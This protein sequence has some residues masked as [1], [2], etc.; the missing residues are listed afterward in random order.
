LVVLAAAAVVVPVLVFPAATA[1]AEDPVVTGETLVGELIQAVPEYL[2]P[3]EAAA[4]GAEGPLSWIRTSGQDVRVDTAG[5]GDVPVGATVEVVVGDEVADAA[6]ADGVEPAREVLTATVVEESPAVPETAPAGGP[7]NE[8]TVVR[9]APP[10]AADDGTTIEELVDLVN[11][12]VTTFWSGQTDGVI[13]LHAT[14]YPT[15]VTTTAPCSSS[16]A[17]W[18]EVA[19]TV[20]FVSGPGKHLLLYIPSV[21]T[22][23]GCSDG[24]AEVK[25]GPGDGGFLYVRYVATSIIAHELGHNFSLQHSA[26]LQCHPYLEAATCQVDTYGDW[27]DVMGISGW[28]LGTLNPPQAAQLG[29][30][31]TAARR[32]YTVGSTGTTSFTLAPTGGR[33]GVRAVEIVVPGETSYWLEY[34]TGVGQ[35]A[36]LDDPSANSMELQSGVLLRRAGAGAPGSFLLDGTPGT[37]AFD[38][39]MQTALPVGEEVVVTGA[40]SLPIAVTRMSPSGATVRVGALDGSL[41]GDGECSLVGA[42]PSSGVALSTLG[43]TVHAFGVGTDRQVWYRPVG[44]NTPGWRSLGG[45]SLYGPATVYSGNTSFVFV[46][47]GDHQLYMRADNGYGWGMWTSLGGYLTGSPAVASLGDGHLRVFGRGGD[48]ELWTREFNNGGW[49]G[50]TYLGGIL[51]SPPTATA[52][53][54]YG[55]VEVAVRGADGLVYT[56]G[57]RRGDGFR[58]YLNRKFAA[59]STLSVP[60]VSTSAFASGR[61]YLDVAGTA[62]MGSSSA[63]WNYGGHFVSNP[64]VENAGGGTVVAGT[65]GDRQMWVHDSRPGGLGGWVSIGGQFL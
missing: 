48:N 1:R 8:V 42:A 36:W 59:C 39:S 4:H 56:M 41:Q 30:L 40:Q 51:T 53:P 60:S 11:T 12:E 22:L 18:D 7:T 26:A 15:W 50:W 13:E 16:T 3:A 27:Y 28:V 14:G 29:V 46:I 9:V 34:R 45:V 65:G 10:G 38:T 25:S 19:S 37:G 6:S 21:Y 2:D 44:R 57:L 47:G 55:Q 23:S 63:S 24:L 64:D 35:D 54:A 49:T 17:M 43:G 31:P 5:L 20:G 52:Y 32:S 61:V 58:G 33:T 62:W